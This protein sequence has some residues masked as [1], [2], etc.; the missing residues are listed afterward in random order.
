MTEREKILEKVKKL[1]NQSKGAEAID[2]L[3]EAMSAAAM[4]QRL[5][6]KYEVTASELDTHLTRDP[7]GVTHEL[8]DWSHFWNKQ[9][10]KWITQLLYV[11]AMHNFCDVIGHGSSNPKSFHLTL[12]GTEQNREIVIYLTIYLIHQ[13]RL[14]EKKAWQNYYGS[15]KRNT[16][17]R[18]F[19]YGVTVALFARLKFERENTVA[20]V[21]ESMA[22]QPSTGAEATDLE[23][24]VANQQTVTALVVAKDKAVQE[25]KEAQFPRLRKAKAGRS[26]SYEGYRQGTHA[27]RT[28]SLN[29]ALA[30]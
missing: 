10:G 8:L 9:E 1:L 13:C 20:S 17:R 14:L 26:S 27:G 6:L 19:F 21:Q 18:S 22:S 16:F 25:Y 23:R 2:E 4:A 29:K 3:E 12:I 15:S 5:M 11:V 7:A 24:L 28:V 30:T